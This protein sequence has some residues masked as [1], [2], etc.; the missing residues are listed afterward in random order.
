MSDRIKVRANRS[1]GELEV[2][3]ATQAVAEWWDR[4]W[5]EV[6]QFS[7]FHDDD[8]R[9]IASEPVASAAGIGQVPE[10]F[11]EHFTG[12]RSD[13]TDVDKV[14]VAAA[15]VQSASQERTFTTKAANEL[16]LD[17]NI[18]IANASQNVRRL[19]QS[20]RVFVVSNG[21]YRVSAI[22]F[23]NLESLKVNA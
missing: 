5:P 19:I 20:K 23:D 15:F 12:F 6:K 9:D 11:G 8:G 2:E 16:L 21:K 14:L 4:L 18:K 22:G 17:Q 1:T 10:I 3:G 7:K 13:I